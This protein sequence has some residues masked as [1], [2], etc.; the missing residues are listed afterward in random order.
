MRPVRLIA[1][2]PMPSRLRLAK[3]VSQTRAPMFMVHI[4]PEPPFDEQ[5][6]EP[7]NIR[8]LG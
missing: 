4:T 2:D 5:S 1:L 3:D 8:V 7:E 6:D